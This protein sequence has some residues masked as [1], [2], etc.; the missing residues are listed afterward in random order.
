MSIEAPQRVDFAAKFDLGMDY[1]TFLQTYGSEADKAKWQAA[2]DSVELSIEQRALLGNFTR[3]MKVLCMAGAWCGDCVAQ[4]PIF[5][6]FEAES[7]MIRI[8]FI[9][10]DADLELAEELQICGA[11]RVPQVIFLSEDSKPTGRFG[12]R[13]L[14]RYRQ[15]AAQLNNL[16]SAAAGATISS[17][18]TFSA[19]VQDWLNEFERNQLILRTSPRLRRKHGD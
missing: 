18:D 3:K 4:C 2:Y 6:H 17:D 12:D 7:P 1:D 11:S 19:V 13:T 16:D 15:L 14:S 9:D 10:R 8:R 5:A